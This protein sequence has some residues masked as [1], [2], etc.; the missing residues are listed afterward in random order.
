MRAVVLEP[1]DLTVRMVAAGPARLLPADDVGQIAKPVSP[2][3]ERTFG[4]NVRRRATAG[5]LRGVTTPSP[6]PLPQTEGS[7]D[8]VEAQRLELSAARHL[9]HAL[10]LVAA[11]HEPG[12]RDRFRRLLEGAIDHA[13]RALALAAEELGALERSAVVAVRADLV[14]I[15]SRA[16]A[17]LVKA[18]AAKAEDAL[19][20]AG[21]LS[22][23]AQRAPTSDACDDGWRRVEA[24]VLGAEVSARVAA[25]TALEL[26]KDAPG[27]TLARS[28]STAARS[29]EAAALAAR[30][31]VAGRN[32][33]YTFH[34]DSA[35]SFGEGWYLAAAGVL[36]GVAIQTEPEKNGTAQAERFLRDAGLSG[37]LQPYRSR[38]RAM[39]HTTEIV[40]RAFRADPTS[41]QRR[42]RAAFLGDE[43]IASSVSGWVDRRLAAAQPWQFV[44][45]K[46]LVWIR[47]GVHHPT[48]NTEFGE[49]AELTNRVRRA[50]LVPVLIGDAI[51][52]GRVPE[53]ALDMIL[54]WKDPVFRQADMRRA[55]LQFF[56]YLRER[57]G[58]V[59]QLGVTTAG[60]D[61][62]ALMGL[63]TLYLTDAP[64]VRMREWVSAVPGYQEVVR[65]S[66][67]LERVSR[68]LS[69]WAGMQ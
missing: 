69:E 55:Q 43:P 65:E 32:H 63:P 47:D 44:G 49:L 67:Y 37:Q 45:K 42:L 41:A 61:G 59:G 3:A 27:S 54:F 22:L 66:G 20:G 60:M 21:Q 58:L 11:L 23:S 6:E 25:M 19:H 38:P 4:C 12:Q 15:V 34:A 33:A 26:E 57:H 28:A 53:G 9:A 48:R 30:R 18:S 51:R 46:A 31:I 1:D 68:V 24:I 39:K 40:G 35:F 36:A 10:D 29:A 52:E 17:T 62:P 14:A 13:G 16:R 64:N 7:A 5:Y 2:S 56:E 50:G 8:D